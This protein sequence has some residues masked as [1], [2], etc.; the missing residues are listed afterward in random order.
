M[1]VNQIHMITYNL[2]IFKGL[3]SKD[4]MLKSLMVCPKDYQLPS[5]RVPSVENPAFGI[6]MSTLPKEGLFSIH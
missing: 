2:R 4:I 5:I 1:Y 6:Q 3:Y